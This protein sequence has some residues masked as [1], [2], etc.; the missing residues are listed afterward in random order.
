[1]TALHPAATPPDDPRRVLWAWCLLLPLPAM[2]WAMSSH[3]M[4]ADFRENYLWTFLGWFLGLALATVGAWLATGRRWNRSLFP[5]VAALFP[6]AAFAYY[7]GSALAFSAITMALG[8]VAIGISPDASRDGVAS[9]PTLIGLALM[10]AVVGWLLP[11][12]MHDARLYLALFGVI[13]LV[14]RKAITR[15]ALAT[16]GA[17]QSL[18]GAHPFWTT[19]ACAAAALA[20]LG[21]WLPS[22]NYDDNA[23]HLILADQLLAGGYYRL[24]VS[25]QIWAVAPWAN[26]VLHGVAALLAGQEARAAVNILWLLLGLSGAFRL[27]RSLGATRVAALA[28]AAV[29]ASH[30]LTT[31]FGSTMQVDGIVAAVLMHFAAEMVSAKGRIP[32]PIQAGALLGL[33]AGL[34]TSNVLYVLLPFAWLCWNAHRHGEWKRLGK[35]VLMAAAIG[36]PSYFYALTITGNP[37][38]PLFNAIFQSPYMPLENF[39]DSRWDTGVDWRSLWDLTFST[40][41]FAESYPG[42]AGIALLSLLPALSLE[43]FRNRPSRWVGAWLLVSGALMFVQIQYLRYVFPA[44]AVL[45]TVGVVGLSRF[46]PPKAFAAAIVALTLANFWLMP[47]TSWIAKTNPWAALLKQGNAADRGIQ[48]SII[49]ERALLARLQVISPQACVLM[50]DQPFVAGA[51]GRVNAMGWYDPRL[52]QSRAWAEADAT[53]ARWQKVLSA[54]GASHVVIASKKGTPLMNALNAVGYVRVDGEGEAELWAS[55]LPAKR[56]CDGRFQRSRDQAHRIVHP[57]DQHP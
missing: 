28:A 1:M 21:L 24:D 48:Q 33:L 11:F 26:N 5:T 25:S 32:A 54:V 38:F 55:A 14:R 39:H 6:L 15:H 17:W 18:A 51:G 16:A 49:P 41:R 8:A 3:G 53:G 13:A 4:F 37:V 52:S 57:G 40:T 30:P 45:C 31:Y 27:A 43:M 10:S 44:I 7:A 23:S 50:A 20:S 22:L 42:A 12:P 36:G 19:F 47:T 35:M 56:R 2:A 29:F 34:K 46:V 9:P